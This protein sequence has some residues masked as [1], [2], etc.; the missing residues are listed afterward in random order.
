MTHNSASSQRGY[1]TLVTVVFRKQLRNLRRS[2]LTKHLAIIRS[3]DTRLYLSGAWY[4]GMSRVDSGSSRLIFLAFYIG[5]Q[6][7][8]QEFLRWFS[9]LTVE[10][11]SRGIS[12]TSVQIENPFKPDHFHDKIHAKLILEHRGVKSLE[13][14]RSDRETTVFSWFFAGRN[15][16]GLYQVIP[17]PCRINFAWKNT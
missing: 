17:G 11:K 8:A 7:I 13:S 2:I 1:V 4:H 14:A 6:C 10:Q 12:K 9:E 5:P 15:F 16:A 3:G